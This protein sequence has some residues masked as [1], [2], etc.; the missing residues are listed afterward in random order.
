MHNSC[1]AMKNIIFIIFFVA[2]SLTVSAQ[3]AVDFTTSDGKTGGCSPYIVSFKNLTT[4]ASANAL[5]K[6]D[7]GNNITSQFLN[8]AA[9]YIE[10]KEYTV[11]LTVTDGG[12]TATKSLQIS[13]Y[14]KP[15]V[16]FSVDK[17]KGCTP[18]NVI[19]TSNSTANDGNIRSLFWD[20]GDGSTKSVSG[21]DTISHTYTTAQN[22]NPRLIITTTYGC[23]NSA[24]KINITQALQPLNASFT[25]DK[26]I[27]CKPSQSV[28]FKTANIIYQ[29]A[30]YLWD[31]GDGTVSNLK[32]PSHTYAQKGIYDVSLILNDPTVAGC[33]GISTMKGLV[34]V[35]DFNTDFTVTSPVCSN[36][37]TSFQNNSSVIP[38]SS[39]WSFSADNYLNN[40]SGNSVT[41]TFSQPG[42]LTARLINTYGTCKDTAQK[43]IV[44]NQ[45]PVLSG[46]IINSHVICSDTAIISFRDTCHT[47]TKWLWNFNANDPTAV[48]TVQTPTYI[49]ASNNNYQINLTVTDK[50]G[51]NASASQTLA[52][53]KPVISIYTINPSSNDAFRGCTGYTVTFAAT[54]ADQIKTFAW[55]LGDGFNSTQQQPTHTY[56]Q[57]GQYPVSLTYTTISG[58]S[59]TI[60]LNNNIT[61]ISKPSANFSYTANTISPA[62]V[63]GN[64]AIVFTSNSLNSDR[65]YWNFGD[66]T[67]TDISSNN[68]SVTHQYSVL[69]PFTVTLVAYNGGCGDTLRKINNITVLPPFTKITNVVNSCDGARDIV[70]FYQTSQYTTQTI[71]NFGDG[72]I[73]TTPSSTTQVTHNFTSNG[74]YKVTVSGSYGPCTVFDSATVYVLLKQQPVLNSN[75]AQACASDSLALTVN[76]L[77]IN[78]YQ[79]VNGYS[80][81]KWQYGDGSDFTG[82]SIA[83]NNNPTDTYT[84]VLTNLNSNKKDLRA[85]V[86]STYFGCTDTTNIVPLTIVGPSAD[87]MIVNTSRCFQST[88]N[89]IDTSSINKN[90]TINKRVWNFGDDSVLYVAD[91]ATIIHKYIKP[92]NFVTTLKVTDSRGCTAVSSGAA[93]AMI[94]YGPKANFQWS[95][96]P[97]NPGIPTTFLNTSDTFNCSKLNYL[98]TFSNNN[99][100]DTSSKQVVYKY[101]N[102]SLDTVTLIAR[103][104][105]NKCA[106]TLIQYVPVNKM[107]TPFTYES[108]YIDSNSC[109][110]LVMYPNT[111][112]MIVNADSIS[113]NFG[114]GS[115]AGN[116]QNPSHTYNQPGVYTIKLYGYINGV[117]D[118]TLQYIT[119]LGPYAKISADAYQKCSPASITLSA[120]LKNTSSY[121][122]DFNDGSV[123]ITRDTIVQH[124]YPQSGIYYPSLVLKDSSGCSSVFNTTTPILMDTLAATIQASAHSF[125]DS[126]IVNLA[127]DVISLAGSQFNQAL[128]YKWFFGTP[129]NATSTSPDTAFLYKVAGRYIVTLL[130]Q[131]NPGCLVRVSDTLTVNP[132][133]SYVDAGPD[134]YILLGKSD[135]LTPVVTDSALNYLWTPP[136]Y[137]S[138]D[139]VLNPVCS[140]LSNVTYTFTAS[141]KEGC[142]RS[143]TVRVFVLFPPVVPNAFSPNGDGINDTWKIKYLD[144]YP[145]ATVDVYSRYGQL[146]FHSNGYQTEWDGTI[147]GQPLTVGTYY[148]IINPK[149]GRAVISGSITIIR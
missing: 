60:F 87:F 99:Y 37:N 97:V 106:D 88:Y 85:I 137:L 86:Q 33:S 42:N 111:N 132:M 50:A 102:I 18:F 113:W 32:A 51:C 61:I 82:T 129:D 133:P 23:Q 120:S 105:V 117:V 35:S 98:W 56:T 147:N 94:I 74:K 96:S 36:T 39:Q 134:K 76:N 64:T 15:T 148:Y 145:G 26:T 68:Q 80:I 20:F 27:V 54:N 144:T 149:N 79:S 58:C 45:A 93:T 49:Y 92:G 67:A 38:S 138:N 78:P 3:L 143:D 57:I 81:L 146:V 69:G 5:Y 75:T 139:T 4:G 28:N 17:S 21:T 2:D 109:P 100:T 40:Y 123:Q 108:N 114:D 125:C 31:F 1:L 24:Q 48:S 136:S 13:V 71:W 66:N 112:G 19:F 131:S 30:N 130:V 6:W 47:A 34:N 107:Y 83:N 89:F 141:T 122:W 52:I 70:N 59:A 14:K 9:T 128:K 53:Q 124:F 104:S 91:S 16:D 77:I 119:I 142:S 8:A 90:L 41:K 135:I 118:S 126:S 121:A 127:S 25:V 101:N 115:I 7:L 95:P 62:K 73:E 84:S 22:L 103:D 11:T 140:P 63:C 43:T 65:W 55:N 116:V 44:V 10:E 29:V 72:R 110:P 12:Q 46:F